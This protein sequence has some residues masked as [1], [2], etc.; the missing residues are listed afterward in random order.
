[1]RE[2]GSI[3]RNAPKAITS[4]QLFHLARRNWLN[5]QDRIISS[6]S[7]P[8]SLHHGKLEF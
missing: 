2:L 4:D 5:L 7:K 6:Q 8:K 1:M 3:L